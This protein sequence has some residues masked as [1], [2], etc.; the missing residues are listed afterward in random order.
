[1]GIQGNLLAR[2]ADTTLRP[3]DVSETHKVETPS[4]VQID[5]RFLRGFK[6]TSETLESNQDLDSGGVESK[7]TIKE[8]VPV[9]LR[10]RSRDQLQHPTEAMKNEDLLDRLQIEAELKELLKQLIIQNKNQQDEIRE[11][12]ST[13]K[14]VLELQITSIQDVQRNIVAILQEDYQEKFDNISIP[15]SISDPKILVNHFS[16]VTTVTRKEIDAS[17]DAS[18]CDSSIHFEPKTT[19][20]TKVGEDVNQTTE[21][22]SRHCTYMVRSDRDQTDKDSEIKSGVH[23]EEFCRDTSKGIRKMLPTGPLDNSAVSYAKAFKATPR[24]E[25]ISADTSDSFENSEISGSPSASDASQET[26]ASDES[27]NGSEDISGLSSTEDSENDLSSSSPICPKQMLKMQPKSQESQ[28]RSQKKGRYIVPTE[29]KK[30]QDKADERIY[31]ALDQVPDEVHFNPEGK[32]TTKTL[33]VGNLDYNTDSGHL[34]KV[35]RKYFRYRIKVDAVTVPDDNGKS[36]GY[37]FV[38][39]SW[40]KAANVNPSDICKL[41]SGMIEVNT[42]YIYLRELRNDNLQTGYLG[43]RGTASIARK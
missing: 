36:R 11:M 5:A 7:N 17:H 23:M 1:M 27:L 10:T 39:L 38:T 20:E 28:R 42:R 19:S 43:R 21:A 12:N 2:E 29:S 33:Y 24:K 8:D 14:T 34:R 40:T 13:L 32:R 9:A 25:K 18:S 16:P 22:S 41:Y 3:S 6:Q 4:V 15:S 31:D 30:V 35:L 37:A 26:E